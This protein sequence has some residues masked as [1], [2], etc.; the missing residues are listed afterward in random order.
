MRRINT[1]QVLLRRGC[2]G[3]SL[4]V[5]VLSAVLVF[6]PPGSAQDIRVVADEFPPYNY[7]DEGE[8]TGASTDVVRAVLDYLQIDADIEIMPW[9]R[10]YRTALDRENIL[11][12]TIARSA[13]REA[14]FKWVGPVSEYN[15]VLFRTPQ[16]A[17]IAVRRIQDLRNYTVGATRDDI[18]AQYLV[19]KGFD[20]IQLVRLG[21]VNIKKLIHGRIDL[22]LENE[23]T[24]YY[25]V[26]KQGLD[27]DKI[28]QKAY[29]LDIGTGYGYMAF[30]RKTPDRIVNRFRMALQYVKDVGAY[31]AI[32]E[33]YH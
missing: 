10:A 19:R 21:G 28:L 11:I 16:R 24:A 32:Q 31:A 17:D 25:F 26:K 15:A 29:V 27:P 6:T 23:L 30:S 33:K 12:Y 2:R 13:E 5:A 7:I 4:A 18:R 20:D 1:R 3:G 9:A 8:V 22:W 14:S